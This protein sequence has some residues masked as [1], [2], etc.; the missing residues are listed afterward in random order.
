MLLY[1]NQLQSTHFTTNKQLTAM[2]Y[3]YSAYGAPPPAAE[4]YNP[5]A[6]APPAYGA[7]PPAYNYPPP[8]AYGG[9]PPGG[10]D[11]V[12]TVFITGFPGDV[13]ERELNNL[14]RFLPGYE[15]GMELGMGELG[16]AACMAECQV[17]VAN[18][19]PMHGSR[20]NA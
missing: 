3:D 5:Y 9:A 18:A 16:V 17:F 11:E 1:P 7:P 6:Y 20:Q 2:S 14:L 4:A 19:R 15:V 13:K 8:A 10:V 12:R